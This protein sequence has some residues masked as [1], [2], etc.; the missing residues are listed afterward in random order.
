MWENQK[1]GVKPAI[2]KQNEDLC[3]VCGSATIEDIPTEVYWCAHCET[4]VI[5]A[6]TQADKGF[7]P[8]CKR[9]MKYLSA[10]LRPVFPEER[11]L[12]ELLLGE[13]P[14]TYVE[15]S[16]WAANSRYYINGKSVSIPSK[17]FQ[18]ADTDALSKMLEQNKGQN[19]YEYFDK[20]I[21]S[22][23]NTNKLRLH[24]LKRRSLHIYQESS[25]KI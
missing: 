15:K 24:Y 17:T 8:L 21:A 5:Q 20:H 25:R 13:K 10:D 1:C 22:F 19:T 11:L 2:L 3:P 23:I 6:A 16:V 18:E 9:K 7:C 4:P 14:F 12:L